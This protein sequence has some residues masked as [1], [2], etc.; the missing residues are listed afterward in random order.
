[1]STKVRVSLASPLELLE[2]RGI[3]PEQARAIIKLRTLTGR[4]AVAALVVPRSKAGQKAGGG[5]S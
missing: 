3:G 1:M 4:T 2:L 5:E